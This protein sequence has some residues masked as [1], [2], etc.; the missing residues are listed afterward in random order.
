MRNKEAGGIQHA[1][2]KSRQ[3]PFVDRAKTVITQEQACKDN[4]FLA[5]R[6]YWYGYDSLALAERYD[7]VDTLFLLLTAELPTSDQKRLLNTFMVSFANLGPRHP[8]VRA[9]VSAAV[10]KTLPEHFLPIAQS[11]LGGKNGAAGE[12]QFV[13][14]YLETQIQDLASE[15]TELDHEN[16]TRALA[17]QPAP[18]FGSRYGSPD[19]YCQAVLSTLLALNS[20]GVALGFVADVNKIMLSQGQGVLPSGLAAAVFYDLG[21]SVYQSAALYQLICAPGII[22]HSAEYAREPRTALPFVS[23]SDY[24]IE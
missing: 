4:P 5:Q 13:M 1:S 21:I 12:I 23:D 6:A 3:E 19:P 14:R 17:D 7:F 16:L 11:V 22:A 24:D 10:G 20:T 18:G 2:V 15:S 8:A 9:G